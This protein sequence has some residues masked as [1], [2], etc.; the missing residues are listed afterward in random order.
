MENELWNLKVKEYNMVAYTQ[1]FN[2]LDLMCPRMVEP[3]S[4]KIDAYIRGLSDNIKGEVTTS[5]STNLNEANN[6]KQGNG[7][8]MITAPNKGKV[9]SRSLHVYER[10]FTFHVGQCTIKFHKCGKI[11]HK[12]RY[13]KE[14]NVA[15]GRNTQPIW[16]CYDY[17]EQSH[18]R[19]RCLKKVKQEEV[20]KLVAELIRLRMLSRRVRMWLRVISCIKARKYIERGCH[21]FVA[22]V[23]EKKSKENR[24]ED[25]PVIRDFLEVIPDDFPGLPLPRQVEF[26]ID[27]VPGAAPVARAPYQLAP[28]KMRELS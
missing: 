5:K 6:Q 26:R 7:R 20:E 19:N 1:R 3:K 14:K 22:H 4:V 27:L 15:T 18:A 11:G 2:E 28:S 23:T 24:L 16:T 21:L 12:A 10:C 8:A 25:V 17:G 9:Y 13:C